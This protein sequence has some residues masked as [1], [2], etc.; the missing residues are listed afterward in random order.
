MVDD[1]EIEILARDDTGE[2]GDLAVSEQRRR[3]GAIDPDNTGMGD[4]EI[5]GGA[6]T[7][8]FF[9][10]CFRTAVTTKVCLAGF[11]TQLQNRL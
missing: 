5:D 9:Q 11:T 8:R 3:L 2:F 4:I 10:T 1:D 7:E 6:Q